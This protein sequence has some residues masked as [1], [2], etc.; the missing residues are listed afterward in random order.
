MEQ[1]KGI[2]NGTFEVRIIIVASFE[3][4]LLNDV[5]KY[6]SEEHSYW[7]ADYFSIQLYAWGIGTVHGLNSQQS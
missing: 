5:H 3:L 6:R 2:F 1:Y 7:L 4:C